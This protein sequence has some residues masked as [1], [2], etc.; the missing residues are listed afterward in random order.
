MDALA[1][2]FARN[3]LLSHAVCLTGLLGSL[4]RSVI[5]GAVNVAAYFPTPVTTVRYLRKPGPQ[6]GTWVAG[7]FSAF[8]FACGLT[9]VLDVWTV[10]QSYDGALV[11]AKA[12][13]ALLSIATAVTVWLLITKALKIPSVGQLQAAITSLEAKVGRR[14]SDAQHG[15]EVEQTLAVTLASREAGFIATDALGQL[16]RMNA[17]AERVTGLT[18]DE[19]RGQSLWTVFDRADRPT[20]MLT[21]T[22]IEVMQAQGVAVDQTHQVV[23]IRPDGD[24]TALQLRADLTHTD[25]GTVRGL[26][27]VFRDMT[28]INLVEA[29]RTTLAASVASSND[30]II[31]KTRD[32]RITSCNRDAQDLFGDSPEQAIGQPAQMLI[33]AERATEEMPILADLAMGRTL[34]PFDTV[35]QARDGT[36]LEVSVAISPISDAEGHIVGASK[37]ARGAKARLRFVP[38]SAQLGA[39]DINPGTGITQQSPRHG[40]GFGL[41][42]SQPSD[43]DRT[44]DT[45]LHHV[46]PDDRTAV[47]RSFRAVTEQALVADRRAPDWQIDCRV[48]WP[49]GSRHW[50]QLHGSILQADGLAPPRVGIG[51]D[52]SAQRLAEDARLKALRQAAENRRGIEATRRKSQFLANISHELRTPQNAISGF[53]D[54]L[55]TGAV[56][57]KSPKHREF[58]G[59]IGTSGHHRLQRINDV[60]DLSKVEAG[61]FGFG[62]EPVDLAQRVHEAFAV[63]HTGVQRKHLTVGVPI[64]PALTGLVIDPA[65]FKQVP[66]NHLLN[67]IKFT[68]NGG[69][70]SL[71]AVPAGA[72]L[73]QVEV[74]DNSIGIAATD[75]PRLFTEFQQLDAGYS[76]QHAGTGL[77]IGVDAA[78]TGG[79]ARQ[80]AGASA[81]DGITLALQLPDQHGLAVLDGIRRAGLGRQ[82]PVTAVTLR[83]DPG[84]S[85]TFAITNLLRKPIDAQKVVSAKAGLR[86]APKRAAQMMVIDNDP[87]TQDL[88]RAT[89]EHLGAQTICRPDAPQAP[90]EIGRHHPDLMMPGFDGFATLAAL[91]QMP[92]RRDTPVLIWASMVLTDDQ[93]NTLACS[94]QA[95][96]AK[97]GGALTGLFDTLRRW[98]PPTAQ[99]AGTP[100]EGGRT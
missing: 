58:L 48:V 7:L 11:L 18:Q 32:G 17:V 80:Q 73:F 96:L 97:G 72:A 56:P 38:D 37:I 42:A 78:A 50:L 67:A 39:W 12:G 51:S 100:P 52:I 47:D 77:G 92:Q 79:Q 98:R 15:A 70:I 2:F 61:K 31:D 26:A 8:T 10:C 64:D 28:P 88:M 69:H 86:L 68:G 13:V 89:L 62:P 27:M 94:A 21:R 57:T 3:G 65:R 36:R 59:H 9:H 29:E 19:A 85:A 91:R 20:E 24:R 22:P 55:Q 44:F 66:C 99:P 14:L 90:R 54:L 16:T 60:L 82:A 76:K 45:L 4:R 41:T 75:L 43:A 34:P 33:P 83:T 93:H 87:P 49:G 81:D 46:H 35:R 6:P 23:A 25:D 84:Q 30:A 71:R 1:P 40:A 5:E 95:V 63:L 74:E 53:A